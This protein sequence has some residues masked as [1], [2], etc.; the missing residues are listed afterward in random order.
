MARSNATHD[1]RRKRLAE[2]ELK[3]GLSVHERNVKD[4]N[5]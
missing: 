3:N 2:K 5:F 1:K 4:L